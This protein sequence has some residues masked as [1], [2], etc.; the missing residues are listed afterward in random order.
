MEEKGEL[1]YGC[2]EHRQE[3]TVGGFTYRYTHHFHSMWM[4]GN[5]NQETR[6]E[7]KFLKVSFQL[8]GNIIIT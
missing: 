2:V 3:G 4:V 5:I 7:A 6:V 1:G 8:A